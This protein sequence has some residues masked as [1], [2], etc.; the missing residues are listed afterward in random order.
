[1]KPLWI[2]FVP[3]GKCLATSVKSGENSVVRSLLCPSKQSQR[4]YWGRIKRKL[5]AVKNCP[6][7]TPRV[8]GERPAG[9]GRGR[10]LLEGL[11]GVPRRVR[12]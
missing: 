3:T 5:R 9:K 11:Q 2:S 7:P 1:M 6:S 12:V 8:R 10:A 4:L